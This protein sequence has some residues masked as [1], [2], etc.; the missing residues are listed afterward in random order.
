VVLAVTC[1]IVVTLADAAYTFAIAGLRR[2]FGARELRIM[3]GAA[4]VMLLAVGLALAV[5]QRG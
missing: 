3:D 2:G 1:V 4:G 5:V